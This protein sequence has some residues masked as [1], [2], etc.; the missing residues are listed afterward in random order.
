MLALV[1]G[2]VCA[3]GGRKSVQ[4]LGGARFMYEAAERSLANGNYSRAIQIY[5]Q[6]EISFPF[7]DEA[8][9]ARL[10]LIYTYYKAGKA[11]EAD[12]AANNFIR[13]NPRDPNVDYAYY[14]RGLVF[15]E[16]DRNFLEKIF[17]VDLSERPPNDAE[18]SFSNFQRLLRSF[19][20][21]RY[22]DDARERMRYLRNRLADYEVHVA[23]Y[24]LGRRAYV[25]AANRSRYVIEN[26]QEAPAVREALTILTKSYQA[27]KMDDLAAD[28][29][30][31]LA[32]NYGDTREVDGRRWFWQRKRAPDTP[33]KATTASAGS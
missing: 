5:E 24:Y 22:A 4:E 8:R 29:R 9:Q 11:E 31:V 21:S 12:E 32:E 14:L 3:C 33:P 2:A 26:Y 16:R 25:A 18:R 27:L 10:D 28:T 19:P 30:R 17:R 20:D 7:S 13:E 15:F 1:A 23:R 6:L